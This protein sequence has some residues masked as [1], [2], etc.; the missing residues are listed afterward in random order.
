MNFPNP[1]NFVD[2]RKVFHAKL[3]SFFLVPANTFDNVKGQFP[4]GF[5]IWNTNEVSSLNDE[6]GDVY[7][8]DGEVIEKKTIICNHSFEN[9]MSKWLSSY[10]DNETKRIGDINQGR[11]DFQNQKYC[12]IKNNVTDLSHRVGITG[13]NLYICSIYLSVRHCIPATWLNDRDQFC[14]PRRVW[15]DDNEFQND[16]L[17]YTLFHGQNRITS[18]EGINHW[19][20]FT[21]K[22][23]SAPM[24][25]E[26][27]FMSDFIAG[28]VKKA[29]AQQEI[30]YAKSQSLIPTEPIRF[31]PEAQAVMEAG[32][33]LWYY[34]MHH[35]DGE[36]YGAQSINVNASYYDIR[37]YFQG[38]ND[39]GMMNKDSKDETYMR[40]WDKVKKTLEVLAK[41]IEP[42][43]YLYGFLLDE[44]TLPEDEPEVAEEAVLPV[45]A[46]KQTRKTPRKP[47]PQTVIHYHIDHVDTFN[48]N[49]QNITVKKDD[50]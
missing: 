29:N 46:P 38:V 8:A 30:E 43:V 49:S 28:R 50:K 44:T 23:V 31:S 2:F 3:E 27:H 32:R 15:K 6:K 19:I 48:D 13:Q 9:S 33:E 18:S 17:A 21:E 26:S 14:A 39:K 10:R 7:N 4:I 41:K 5:F 25:F 34:Y 36:L 42:K 24:L 35:K 22:D 47:T 11:N 12:Y 1:P 45:K 37:R 16:C 40:L 20:P